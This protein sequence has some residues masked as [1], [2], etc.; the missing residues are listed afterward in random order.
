M[1]H[2][3]GKRRRSVEHRSSQR[4]LGLTVEEMEDREKRVRGLEER[5][6]NN[7]PFRF[8]F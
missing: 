5:I 2:G 1:A 3:G 7:F 6:D 8:P 4:G